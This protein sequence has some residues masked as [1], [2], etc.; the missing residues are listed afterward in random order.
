MIQSPYGLHCTMIDSNGPCGS[1]LWHSHFS[2]F[3]SE[4]IGGGYRGIRTRG[5][6][7]SR[8]ITSFQSSRMVIDICRL[9]AYLDRR[10]KGSRERCNGE[11][12][13]SRKCAID[14]S[15]RQASR[16]GLKRTNRVSSRTD[17]ETGKK[18]IRKLNCRIG[19]LLKL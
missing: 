4:T 19:C 5:L 10:N 6:A 1:P 14:T 2:E 11:R 12:Q 18:G 13:L 3:R 16:S 8:N 15:G 17:D 9:Q 7:F